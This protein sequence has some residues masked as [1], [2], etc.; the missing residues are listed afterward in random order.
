MTTKE[1]LFSVL[2]AAVT[3]LA[4]LALGGAA[5]AQ[6]PSPEAVETARQIIAIK[7]GDTI[8]N[9]LIPGVIEQG[10]SLFEQQNPALGKDL[11]DVATKLRSEL[12]PQIA[13][14]H[15]EVAKLYASH[16]TLK[17]LKEILAFYQ[18]PLG[19]KLITEEPKTLDQSMLFAQNWSRKFSDE[20]LTKFRVEMKKLG[21]D[22]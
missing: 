4:L 21:H 6:D 3:G 19:R 11:R 12:A 9:S 10:K 13:E 16:F 15:T 22:I 2:R 17:E 18:S 7:G 1:T 14:V 5:S 8:F 20:V